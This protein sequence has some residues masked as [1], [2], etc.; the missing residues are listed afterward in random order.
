MKD[1]SGDRGPR[2]G[3]MSGAAE[4]SNSCRASHLV[5]V[6]SSAN[7]QTGTDPLRQAPGREREMEGRWDGG[8]KEW[9]EG[10]RTREQADER[11]ME[12]EK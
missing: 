2:E 12:E 6:E 5:H 1:W 9:E 7:R 4:Q 10:E 11:K 3:G 8:W